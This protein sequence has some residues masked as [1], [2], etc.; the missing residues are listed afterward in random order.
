VRLESERV[1]NARYQNIWPSILPSN[2]NKKYFPGTIRTLLYCPYSK[3]PVKTKCYVKYSYWS[4]YLPKYTTFSPKNVTSLISCK[5]S[6]KEKYVITQNSIS[7]V[8]ILLLVSDGVWH[9]VHSK[10]WKLDQ[11]VFFNKN[12]MQKY[13]KFT[14]HFGY[15]TFSWSNYMKQM[16]WNT[17]WLIEKGVKEVTCNWK[18]EICCWGLL[19]FCIYFPSHN[20]CPYT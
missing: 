2:T 11:T 3:K 5:W 8:S 6:W 19:Y 17:R 10:L 9:D 15:I 1:H 7:T 13:T 14:P 4:I 20:V 18:L 12:Q 16:Y